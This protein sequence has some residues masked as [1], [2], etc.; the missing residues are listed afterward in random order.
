[1][2]FEAKEHW[3]QVYRTKAT[4]DVSW[5]QAR[6]EVSLKLIEA[7]GVG[8]D[9]AIVDVGGGASVLVDFL[10][11]AGFTRLA[12]LD[13]SGAALEHARQRLGARAGQVEWVE[14]DVTRFDPARRFDLWHDRA[15]FH[16]LTDKADRERYVEA[17]K[18]SLSAE[19]RVIIATFALDGPSRCSGLEVARYDARLICAELGSEFKLVEEVGD[20]HL[21]PWSTE[22]R[23][24]YF[25][26]R[27]VARTA[28]DG[29]ALK[30]G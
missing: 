6:P 24:G 3:E 14:A 12:V 17:L 19:G 7:C 21:T 18:R 22:Q 4:N 20:I 5:Y 15:V 13:I 25:R 10:L 26:F 23:F 1:M 9:Q 30:P 28:A 11:G 2:S 8:K 29:V 16:F 27:R